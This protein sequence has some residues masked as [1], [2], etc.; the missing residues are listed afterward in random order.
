MKNREVSLVLA[1]GGARGLAHIGVIDELLKREF[2]INSI[3]GSSM[4]AIVAGMYAAGTLED[5]KKWILK[6]K[7]FD[8]LSLM[9]FTLGNNGIIKGEKIFNEMKKEG[10]IPEVDI[11]NLEIPIAIVASDIVNNKEIVFRKGN[12]YNALRA[13]ISIPNVFTPVKRDNGL[14][15]DGGVLNPL[16]LNLVK[17][18]SNDILMAVDINAL[19]PYSPDSKKDNAGNNDGNDDK[20]TFE[21]LKARWFELFEGD[22][23]RK[24]SKASNLGYMDMFSRTYQVMQNRISQFSLEKDPPDVH[25]EISKDA[26]GTFEFYRAKEMIELGRE[27]CAKALDKANL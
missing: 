17:R 7:K 13:S 12:L 14:L 5:Y 16:P 18:S 27:S 2:T 26:C 19:I 8:V 20:S 10:F 23:R 6:L 24:L 3:S 15:V 22:E 25:I 4:G 9:D 11:E 21:Q 1:S